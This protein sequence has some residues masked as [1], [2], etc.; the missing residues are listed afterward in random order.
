[1]RER[2]IDAIA[3]R[4]GLDRVTARRRNLVTASEMP[5]CRKLDALGTEIVYDSGDYPRL[6]DKALAKIGWDS[7]QAELQ[8][9]RAAGELVGNSLRMQHAHFIIEKQETHT[10]DVVLRKLLK[11]V[12]LARWTV[13]HY[14]PTSAALAR[15]RWV[16]RTTTRLS[17]A[18]R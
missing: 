7:L 17:T 11:R 13:A 10:G 14:K 9:R 2:L 16:P 4:L 15:L 5:F 12:G 6:L 18:T 8:R 3:D 1:V